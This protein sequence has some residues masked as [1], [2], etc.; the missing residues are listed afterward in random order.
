MSVSGWNSELFLVKISHNKQEKGKSNAINILCLIPLKCVIQEFL[1]DCAGDIISDNVSD[2]MSM[3]SH[4]MAV[5]GT[6][7]CGAGTSL[8]VALPDELFLLLT[9]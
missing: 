6:W 1:W 9:W 4:Y 7:Q 8:T 2:F 3:Q 5:L